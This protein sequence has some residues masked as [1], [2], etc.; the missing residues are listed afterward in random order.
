M[1]L[2]V[3][4]TRLRKELED[5]SIESSETE[6]QRQQ[7]LRKVWGNY[8]RFYISI[9]GISEGED[10]ETGAEYI[11]ETIRTQN[12]PQLMSDTKPQIQE[13]QRTPRRINAPKLHLCI[14]FSNYRKSKIKKKI[15]E[16]AKGRKIPY[17]LRN[18]HKIRC[19]CCGLS[20]SLGCRFDPQP[21][22][23]G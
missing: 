1:S 15:M 11:F 6:K 9:M 12:F 13:S 23:V 18:K 19:S 2:L 21:S 4:W 8:K 5:I 7:R 10:I 14:L 16:E 3:D 22:T 17:L 20:E